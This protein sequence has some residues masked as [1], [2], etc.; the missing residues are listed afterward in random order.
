MEEKEFLFL[1]SGMAAVTS[2]GKQGLCNPEG[3]RDG[4]ARSAGF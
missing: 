1:G 3:I 4:A 2:R